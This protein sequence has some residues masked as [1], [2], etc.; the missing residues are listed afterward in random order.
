MRLQ[1]PLKSAR[2]GQVNAER[3]V[4]CY[5]EEG[6]GRTDVQ[7]ISVPGMRVFS[8]LPSGSGRGL[9]VHNNE[10]YAVA[11]SGLYRIDETGVNTLIG[12][13]AGTG[14][15]TFASSGDEM[16]I[17][18]DG[19]GYIYTTTLAQITDVDFNGADSVD[20]LDGFF[21][22]SNGG[23]DFQI[24]ALLA[25]GTIDALDFASAESNPDPIIRAFVDHREL[26]L[27][28]SQTIE[29][30]VNTGDPDFP[31]ERVSG[32]IAEKGLAHRNGVAKLDNTVFWV[33]NDGIVRRLS[34]GLT[35]QR[36]STHEVES[37]INPREAFETFA[38]IWQGHEF[39]VVSTDDVTFIYDAA[40]NLWHERKSQSINR[41]R[42]RGYGYCYGKHY[43]GDYENGTVYEL[44]GEVFAEGDDDLITEMVFP[45][46]HAD[47]KRFR[48]H[49]LQ[50]DMEV[51][52]APFNTAPQIRLDLS[53]DGSTWNTVGTNTLGDTGKRTHR[54]AFRRL[55]QH[56]NLH[57]KIIVSDPCRRAL[58][59][60]YAEIS[61]DN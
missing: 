11:G 17:A 58:Y 30:W 21:I 60:A 50:L 39:F 7:V 33:D 47:G 37:R 53:E 25:G 52:E 14:I 8:T 51:G 3:L 27:F 19:T 57:V 46:V 28:G 38:F 22:Y 36:I 5:A 23:Q 44:T 45:C 18:A 9:F 40:T 2:D 12:N 13:I 6:G 1:I 32:G 56:R 42:A 26:L 24:S 54:I 10:L 41:W 4:N 29:N 34:G 31:F 59:N 49:K 55:G 48:L 20:Y 15:C 43:V 61:G 16:A 35:P